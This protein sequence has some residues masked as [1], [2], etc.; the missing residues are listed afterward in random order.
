M[1]T[2]EDFIGGKIARRITRATESV[3][4]MNLIL[5]P[6]LTFGA[7]DVA[8]QLKLRELHSYELLSGLWSL[9]QWLR[10]EIHSIAAKN[11]RA[12]ENDRERD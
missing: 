7:G 3:A 8:P 2:A 9:K 12:V 10:I 1:L 4:L 11:C 5:I 6:M